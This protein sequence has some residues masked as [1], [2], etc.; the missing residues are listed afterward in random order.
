MQGHVHLAIPFYP[1]RVFSIYGI[2]VTLP[3]SG[4]LTI[5]TNKVLLYNFY[6]NLEKLT[7]FCLVSILRVPV[8]FLLTCIIL[9]IL[10]SIVWMLAFCGLFPALLYELVLTN[11]TYF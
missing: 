5:I 3:I 7:N 11:P 4:I 1:L 10:I 9:Y 8:P 2:I 6:L